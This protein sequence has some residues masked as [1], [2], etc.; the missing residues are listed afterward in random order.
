MKKMLI[1]TG[2]KIVAED[3]TEGTEWKLSLLARLLNK[4]LFIWDEK[5]S[6]HK[7]A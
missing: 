4:S 3:G 5:K 1:A 6:T 7:Q 2:Q